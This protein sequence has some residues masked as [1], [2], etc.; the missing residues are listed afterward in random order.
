MTWI[1]VHFPTP[2]LNGIFGQADLY[3]APTAVVLTN[4]IYNLGF[5]LSNEVDLANVAI[6]MYKTANTHNA[7]NLLLWL[8]ITFGFIS[9]LFALIKKIG[10]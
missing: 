1:P 4:T 9:I 6:S 8:F 5:S 3:P 10:K 2:N 7:V